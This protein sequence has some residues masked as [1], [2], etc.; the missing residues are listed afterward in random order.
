MQP[1]TVSQIQRNDIEILVE[2]TFDALIRDI[3]TFTPEA[4]NNRPSDGGWTAG[5]VAEHLRRSYASIKELP[6]EAKPVFRP[7]DA[8]VPA[9][10]A[11]FL[12]FSQKFESAPFITPPEAWYDPAEMAAAV[13]IVRSYMLEAAQ[14]HDLSVTCKN[15]G[16]PDHTRL[17]WMHFAVLHTQRHMRQMQRLKV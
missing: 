10:K 5:Q 17:E 6:E 12:D 14:N 13:E 8:N 2:L 3:R 1:S 16:F 11:I 4:F 7:L 9:L 15:D